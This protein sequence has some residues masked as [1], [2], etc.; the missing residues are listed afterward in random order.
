MSAAT[1]AAMHAV[2]P[3]VDEWIRQ[4]GVT[5]AGDQYGALIELAVFVQ[6][7]TINRAKQFVPFVEPEPIKPETVGLYPHQQTVLD[8]LSGVL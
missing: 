2:A 6:A 4:A 5:V 7:S 3:I 1:T 8:S